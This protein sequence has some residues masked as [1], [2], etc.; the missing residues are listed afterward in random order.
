MI[1]VGIIGCGSITRLRH[2]PEYH[3]NPNC[4]LAIFYDAIPS[5]AKELAVIYGANY[6][7]DYHDILRDPQID[8]VSI[9]TPNHTHAPF[10][11]EALHHGKHVLCEKPMAIHLA[12]AKDM[13]KQAKIS[14]KILMIGF[15]Q[16]FFPA[17]QK[18]KEILDSGVLGRIISFR[19]SFKHRG[20]E[21]WSIEKGNNT[22]FF[23][24]NSAFFGALGDLGIHKLD[25]IQWLTNEKI[26]KVH[27]VCSTLDK[28]DRNGNKISVDDNSFC[29]LE[30]DTITGTM[31]ASWTC[32][33]K[34]YNSTILYCE[35][36]VMRIYDDSKYDLIINGKDHSVTNMLLGKAPTNDEQIKSGVIDEFIDS[37]LNNRQPCISLDDAVYTMSV[38]LACIESSKI[39]QAVIPSI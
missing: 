32:Y 12:E 38:T 8:A 26:K 3:Q 16:R 22:W 29:I 18:A 6:T 9:C 37:I 24:K 10:T 4:E 20:P 13:Q 34:E 19:T 30:T 23:N 35:K 39:N 7:E 2:A 11:I 25:L 5:R 33:G 27:A 17:H 31:E 28:R 15:N 21:N 1:K 14:E 36:G